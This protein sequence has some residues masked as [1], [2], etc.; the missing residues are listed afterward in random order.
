M[1][2]LLLLEDTVI[3]IIIPHLFIEY[4][5]QSISL[6]FLRKGKILF[7]LLFRNFVMIYNIHG[8]FRG[9]F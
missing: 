5:M 6:A 2:R 3:F 8:S 7:V 1:V 9:I 4:K